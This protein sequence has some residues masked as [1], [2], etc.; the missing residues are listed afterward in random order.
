MES[1]NDLDTKPILVTFVPE[2]VNKT[3]NVPVICDK[4]SEDEERFRMMLTLTNNSNTQVRTGRDKAFGIIRDSTGNDETVIN[5][6]DD[7]IE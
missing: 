2:I 5:I 4:R 3:F 1:G 7:M 6:G